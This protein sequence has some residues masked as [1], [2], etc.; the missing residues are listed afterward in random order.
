MAIF[1]GL[2]PRRLDHADGTQMIDPH[3]RQSQRGFAQRVQ[4]AVPQAILHLHAVTATFQQLNRLE[5]T[6][7]GTRH[8]AQPV[9][10]PESVEAD[11]ELGMVPHGLKRVEH[12]GGD[13]RGV[14]ADVIDRYARIGKRLRDLQEIVAQKRFATREPYVADAAGSQLIHKC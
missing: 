13:K 4:V 1:G 6:F 8:A 5:R 2:P 12:L 11:V 14:R 9:V 3:L 10:V 7:L